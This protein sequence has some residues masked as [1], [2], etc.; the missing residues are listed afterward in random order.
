MRH[1]V[2]YSKTARFRNSARVK[3]YFSRICNATEKMIGLKSTSPWMQQSII[4][5]RND[6]ESLKTETWS[7]ESLDYLLFLWYLLTYAAEPLLRSCQFCS[8]PRTCQHFME[9]EGSL[10]CSQEPSTG[11]Y[12]QPDRSSPYHPILSLLGSILILSTHLRLGLPTGLF[13]SDF[14]INILYTTTRVKLS[15]CLLN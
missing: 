5:K 15:L 7:V 10:P 1:L 9:R 3:T 13:P 4:S 14:P 11:P 2:S 6:H 8:Y 12:P